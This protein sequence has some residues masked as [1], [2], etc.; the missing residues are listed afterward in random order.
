MSVVQHISMRVP[1]RDRPWD[2]KVCAKPIDNSSCLL[3]KGI[4]S[5]RLDTWETEVAAR[6]FNDLS[7]YSALPCLSERGTFMSSHGYVLEKNHPYR[8]NR[9]LRGHLLPTTISV[10]PFAFEAVPFRWL[11]RKSVE[12]DLWQLTDDYR[13]E[14]EDA[15]RQAI[16][17]HPNWLM[18]GRNQ[19]AMIHRFFEDVVDGESLVLMYLKYSPLQEQTTRRL[20]VGAAM[21]AQQRAPQMW[22]QSGSQPFDSSMW[23]TVVSHSLRPDQ[24]Q[25]ILLPY[26][27]LIELMES[28]V[29]VSGA[30]AWAP[31]DADIEFSYV[32][33]HVSDDTAIAAL[34]SLQKAAEGMAA[35]G[36]SVPASA[37]EWVHQQIER[38]W[39]IR[40]PAPGLAAVLAFVGA[41]NPHHIVRRLVHEPDWAQ[42]PWR[43]VERALRADG[44]IANELGQRLPASVGH[45]WRGLA[46]DEQTAL[47]ILSAMDVGREQVS[48]LMTGKSTSLVSAEELVS[49]PYY[50]ATCTYRSRYPIAL[51][52]V[53]QACFP[54]PHVDWTNVIADLSG[55]DDPG[56]CRRLE[57]LMVEVLERLAEQGDTIAGETQVL[58][59]ASEI[60]LTRACPVGRS[61]LA[62]YQLDAPSLSEY[63]YWTPLVGAELEGGLPAYKLGHLHEAGLDISDHLRARRGAPRFSTSFNARAYIDDSFGDADID[64]T[65]EELAR[66]EKAAGLTELFAS[67][68]S[69]LVG[70]AGTGKTRLLQTLVS[71]DE[72]MQDGV[73]LLAP[74]GKARV[75]MQTKVRHPARTLASFLIKKGG[76]DP[77]TG[78]YRN[79]QKSKRERYG[80]VIIDEASMLT[81]EMLAAALSALE[82]VKRL[83]LVG[84][85]RQLPPIGAGRPFVDI[86]EWLKPD[87]L[88]DT[89]RVAPGYVELT[90]FRRFR[91]ADG[92]RD[93]LALAQWF[94]GGDLP[95][96]ADSIWQKIRLGIDSDT[97][98]FRKW[99]ETGVAAT[100]QAAIEAEL[101]LADAP[102]PEKAF[103][104]TYGGRLSS[105]GKYVNWH[106]GDDG[107]GDH[108]ED[109]Q[110]L[111]PTRSRAF[112]TVELNRML[113]QSYRAGDLESAMKWYGH[114]PPK[115]LGPEQIVLGDKV[116]Q[117]R[118]DGDA[119]GHPE[120][121]G[122]DYVANGEIGVVV[123]RA[124]KA[125]KY[126]NVEFSSQIGATYGYMPSSSDD[127]PLELA[128]AVTVHKSQGSEF[129][130][131]FLVLP[132]RVAISRELLYT[133]LTR[134]TRKVVILHDGPI[135]DLFALTSPAFSET[136]RRMT[137][138]FRKP[139]PRE[140]TI[141]DGLKRFDSNLIHVAPGDVLVRS[142]N[143]VIVASILE[144]LAPDQWSYERPLTID[145]VTKYPDFTIE[146]EDTGEAIIW[147]HLGMMGNRKYAQD[148]EAKKQWYVQHGFRPFDDPEAK[149]DRGVLM[150]TDDLTGVDQ[151]AW[152][153]RARQVVGSPPPARRPAK[154]A[155]GKRS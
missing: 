103:Q 90:V 116:M 100:L 13:P 11:N 24:R 26:Q 155:V 115:P 108:C 44:P 147:E 22:K 143:E 128:W 63:R 119:K 9:A 17:F 83:V 23:E 140:L 73:L 37:T 31:E 84:D 29:D 144:E 5:K 19:R 12:K 28:G 39:Q 49:N 132:A 153:E 21:V 55:L 123:S 58:T 107:A 110:V 118:N 102:D 134:Q 154:K 124:G 36:L 95:G 92:E 6:S 56:D 50:A 89:I 27:K 139:A 69:V 35:L 101:Q 145:G 146:K 67:R 59:A 79:V 2:D 109:W 42:D 48:S 62:A 46:H 30:L 51:T 152:A 136:A 87:S 148:W 45:S 129:R 32:T 47:K 111:S 65:Q 121:V 94:G 8:F 120:G 99:D 126:A 104:L 141:G 122:L 113:K 114:R 86:V 20:L 130:T 71:R 96:A 61:L 4:G 112:G 52:T 75:Q 10:P 150:W 74:T 14:R 38:L 106:T 105:D 82:G 16:G 77:H 54:A 81:E 53:D 64:D 15:A 138:L 127:P 85:H 57:A 76:F 66:Q 78:R 125:P 33:D 142:K 137:D 3:L 1:W 91:G 72:I 40:G 34:K 131:T 7:D 41:E 93:D 117:T 98:G 80:L 68:L 43:V 133:A 97:L 151:P 135:D 60:S 88:P 70:P 18:D 149:G 25:G